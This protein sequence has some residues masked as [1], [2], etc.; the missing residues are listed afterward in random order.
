MNLRNCQ[1]VSLIPLYPL[2]RYLIGRSSQLILSSLEYRLPSRSRLGGNTL[3]S[4]WQLSY[5]RAN[6]SPQNRSVTLGTFALCDRRVSRFGPCQVV[7]HYHPILLPTEVVARS[8][9]WRR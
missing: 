6:H 2:N 7:V 5:A 3:A 9:L 1:G 4:V 8:V